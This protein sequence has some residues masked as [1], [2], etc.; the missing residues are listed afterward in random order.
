MLQREN[1]TERTKKG[2]SAYNMISIL[3]GV[4]LWDWLSFV[5]F[6]LTLKK[7]NVTCTFRSEAYAVIDKRNSGDANTY[8]PCQYRTYENQGNTFLLF[9]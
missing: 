6:T 2:N 3:I 5:I 9:L 8:E 7:T 1:L 4:I